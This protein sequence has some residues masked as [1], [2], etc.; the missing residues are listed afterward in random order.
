MRT[1]KDFNFKNKRVLVRVDFQ[2]PFIK[3]KISDDFKIRL[4]IPTIKYLIKKGAK[5]ILITHC[6]PE[7]KGEV[8][9]LKPI[10]LRLK[11]LLK[12]Q[13]VRF[14]ND[15][16]GERIE[17]EIEKMKIGDIFLL[18]NLRLYKEE[19]EN[20]VNFGKRLAKLGDIFINDAFSVCHRSHASV[21]G[22]PKYLP[23]A[24]GLL[25][26]KEIKILSQILEK[27]KH[28]LIV[29]IGGMKI[30]TKIKIIEKFLKNA[31]H[32][33]LGGMLA[34]SILIGKELVLHKNYSVNV[35]DFKKIVKKIDIFS[36]KIHLPVDG[37]ISLADIVNGNQKVLALGKIALQEKIYDIGPDTIRIF[38]EIIK[39]A[40]TI[41]WNGPLGLFEDKRFENGTKQIAMEVVKKQS[42]FK[43][44]GGGDTISAL[45]KLNLIDKFDY[46]SAGGGAMLEFLS[47]EKL[48]GIEALE[49]NKIKI[50]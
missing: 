27:P 29:I 39:T 50:K 9:N 35:L 42:A 3:G 44:A 43:V 36:T 13:K 6:K 12:D 31:D 41:F 26:E 17:R 38:C 14:L 21:V 34:N 11:K 4:V 47:G 23:S 24:S 22:I 15:C 37:I 2:V 32:I 16:I 19:A 8:Q 46:I 45:N 1:I 5:I 25:L 18:E 33:L 40:K 30:E 28:P 20:D 49:K 48:P 7:N 10:F